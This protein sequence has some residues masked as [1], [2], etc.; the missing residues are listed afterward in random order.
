MC[1][2]FG[3]NLPTLD[4]EAGKHNPGPRCLVIQAPLRFTESEGFSLLVGLDL[5]AQIPWPAR[6]ER[7]RNGQR[8][9]PFQRWE[10]Q[11]DSQK[12]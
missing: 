3:A 7:S 8:E 4:I 6:S 1:T 2:E 11:L 5:L 12:S 10:M 9:V